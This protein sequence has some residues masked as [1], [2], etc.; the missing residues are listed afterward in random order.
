MRGALGTCGAALV[1]LVA[2]SPGA[3]RA[4]GAAR[5]DAD[6][7]RAD[8]LF[9]AGKAL[10]EGGQ[11]VDAC[12]KFAES[13]R[14]AAGLGVT[15]YLADCYERIGRTASAWTEFRSAEGLARQR[16]DKRAAVARDRALTLEGKLDRLTILV[17]P[18]VPR[19][20]LQILRDGA[21]IPPEEWGVAVPVDPGDH[22]VVASA[23]G[24]ASRTLSA[25]LG[26]EGATATVRVDRLD[27]LSASGASLVAA[28][29][30]PATS[31]PAEASGDTSTPG[32]PDATRRWIGVGVGAAGLAG[33]AIGAVFGLKAKSKLDQ[34]NDGPCDA[35]DQ[36]TD[37][38]RQIRQ[39]AEGAARV[40]TI[41][42]AAGA[43]AIGAGV[44]LYLTAPKSDAAPSATVGIA[45]L[46][47]PAGGGAMLHARF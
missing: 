18:D 36:C 44:I 12:A 38:G 17:A 27:D 23:A 41:A 19:G 40:A 37:A 21:A 47:L 7:R 9:D 45:P 11:Y 22:V 35:A 33:V 42:F 34:S 26:P 10:L 15:L 29:P 30:A 3:A 8:S 16:G 1:A 25:H 4:Q 46:V 6:V 28:A 13:K 43:A 2:L 14:L 24:H 39:D 20:E 5:D 31:T 32:A